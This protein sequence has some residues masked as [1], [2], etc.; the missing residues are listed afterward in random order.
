MQVRPLTWVAIGALSACQAQSTLNIFETERT[1]ASAF[2]AVERVGNPT[3]PAL[4]GNDATLRLGVD[5]QDA[6]QTTEAAC[7]GSNVSAFVRFQNVPEA[8]EG[9]LFLLNKT[10]GTSAKLF[11]WE[12][13]AETPKYDFVPL[14]GELSNLPNASEG[15]TLTDTFAVR[16]QQMNSEGLVLWQSTEE[17]IEFSMPNFSLASVHRTPQSGHRTQLAAEIS[18][19][20]RRTLS[21]AGADYKCHLSP[22]SPWFLKMGPVSNPA[23]EV[24]PTV[25]RKAKA[26]NAP[27]VAISGQTHT[28]SLGDLSFRDVDLL[29]KLPLM[30]LEWMEAL[31]EGTEMPISNAVEVTP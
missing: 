6:F 28:V 10:R 20:P 29:K 31:A 8:S 15:H 5:P 19:T 13:P 26:S 21:Q 24:T 4:S 30:K 27:W 22:S 25:Y 3:R 7:P 23:Q 11:T 17:E 16:L 14:E 9:S 1:G 2:L 18:V 12:M